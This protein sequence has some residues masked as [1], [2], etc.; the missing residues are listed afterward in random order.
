MIRL[1]APSYPMSIFMS[2]DMREAFDV[3]MEYCERVG[4]CVTLN[5]TGY[6]YRRQGRGAHS[7]GFVVGLIN[8][9]RFPMT[10]KQ[11]WER[12]EQLAALLC[13]RVEAE[14]YTIQAPDR[15]VFFSHRAQDALSKATSK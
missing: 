13:E 9:P 8:Y 6:I 15:T 5:G 7:P 12:A 3:C 11:L 14:S 2:G 4:F 10:P 1:E